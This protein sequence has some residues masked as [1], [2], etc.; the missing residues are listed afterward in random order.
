[1][2]K[3]RQRAII[4]GIV[5]ILLGIASLLRSLGHSW[6]SMERLWPLLLIIGGIYWLWEGFRAPIQTG[7]IWLGTTSVLCGGLFAY[8]TLGPGTWADL[9]ELWP[10]FPLFAGLGWVVAWFTKTTDFPNLIAGILGLGVGGIGFAYTK[11]LLSLP[12]AQR[13]LSWWPLLLIFLGLGLILEFLL[14][15]N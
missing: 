3:E 9:S 10:A 2:K 7:N 6:L 11:G 13:L 14:Q 15:H 4:W 8:I 12:Y 5:L 1:M